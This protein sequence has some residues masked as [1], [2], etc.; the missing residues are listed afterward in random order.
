MVMLTPFVG[1]ATD[2]SVLSAKSVV[3]FSDLGRLLNLFAF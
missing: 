3:L 1:K 2:L